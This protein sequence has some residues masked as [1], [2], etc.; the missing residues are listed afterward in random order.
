MESTAFELDTAIDSIAEHG[1]YPVQDPVIGQRIL[2]MEKN[3]HQFSTSSAPGL[4]F[5]L[6]N[7]LNN[8]GIRGVLEKSF[9]SCALGDYRRIQ[10]DRQH[11]FQLKR[12]GA[13][14]DGLVVQLWKNGCRGIYWRGSHKVSPDV[15]KSYRGANRMFEIAAAKLRR[16]G[17][18]SVSVDFEMGGFVILDARLAFETGIGSPVNC[19]FAPMRQLQRWTKLEL[20]QHDDTSELLREVRSHK[21]GVYFVEPLEGN[22]QMADG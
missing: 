12:G 22:I 2:E 10:E 21:L 1:F 15:L 18:E 20:P 16:A 17:C 14:A 5:Y 4:Q 19:S 9:E 8:E 6:D 3:K 7:I 11:N 13:K